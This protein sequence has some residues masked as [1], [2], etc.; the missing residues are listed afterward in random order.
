MSV[1]IWTAPLSG[2][3]GCHNSKASVQ[4]S[5]GDVEDLSRETAWA[6]NRET[7]SCIMVG[8]PKLHY[9]NGRGRVE[10]IEWPLA[11]AGVESEE[12]FTEIPEDFGKLKNDVSLMFQQAP[13]VKIDGMRLV[14]I[15]AILNDIATK[16]NLGGRDM[17]ERPWLTCM[18]EVWQS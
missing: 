7:R 8:K 3:E 4:T 6:L 2:G 11:A 18:Q 17:K 16:Y 10:S 12:K 9:F 1:G 13:M 15:R 14:Q 5:G